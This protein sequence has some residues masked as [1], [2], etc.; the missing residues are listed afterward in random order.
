MRISFPVV[1]IEIEINAR[2]RTEPI[3]FRVR[4]LM[5]TVAL[6]AIVVYLLLPLS[7][8]H[9]PSHAAVGTRLPARFL[10]ARRALC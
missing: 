6:M 10:H 4:T 5:I 7:A 9:G 3:R 1:P 8:A 2:R